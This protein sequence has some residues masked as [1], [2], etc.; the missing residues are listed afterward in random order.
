MAAN[1][2]VFNK[3]QDY[4]RGFLWHMQCEEDGGVRLEDGCSYGVFISRL[5]DGMEEGLVWHRM[6]LQLLSDHELP[7]SISFYAC[8]QDLLLV[9]GVPRPISQLIG[10]SE[11]ALSMDEKKALFLPMKKYTVSGSTDLLLHQVRGRYL[12]F[13][14]E[15]Y[16][17]AD[18]PVGIRHMMVY[19]PEQSWLSYLP[20]VYDRRSAGDTFL[21]RFLAIFQSMYDDLGRE[22]ASIP[23][24]LDP[25]A[26]HKETLMWLAGWLGIHHVQLWSEPA[27]RYLVSHG[28]ELYGMRGTKQGIAQFVRLYTGELPLIAEQHKIEDF[29]DDPI[30][31][32]LLGELYGTDPN[33]FTIFV[34]AACLPTPR[35]FS[36]LRRIIED[37]KPAHMEFKLVTLRPYILLDSYSYLGIN[38]VL[39]Q[40]RSLELNGFSM[41]SFSALN[42]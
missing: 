33:V 9:E 4:R 41:L 3:A 32:R 27:L 14:A 18:E 16:K 10:L 26:A 17:A 28:S 23:R 24:Y 13:M 21:G 5:L 8:D 22:I 36:D 12:W 19:F 1:Y 37:V 30:Q 39:S 42:K 11:Q 7:F 2:Y 15:F 31:Y 38:S 25:E 40:Y 6:T 34:R 29:S 35:E 20:A